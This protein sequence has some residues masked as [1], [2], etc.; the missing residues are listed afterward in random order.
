MG[1]HLQPVLGLHVLGMKSTV[2]SSLSVHRQRMTIGDGEME[3]KE[4]VEP[5]DRMEMM[6][7]IES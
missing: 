2:H 1:V 4:R 7:M 3:R 6:E 5:M